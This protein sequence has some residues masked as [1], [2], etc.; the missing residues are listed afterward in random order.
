MV[1][2]RN[3]VALSINDST[4]QA[5]FFLQERYLELSNYRSE[6]VFPSTV[7]IMRERTAVCDS[8]SL[9]HFPQ[10]TIQH[11]YRLLGKRSSDPEV[12]E[13]RQR[14]PIPI[15]A[16]AEGEVVFE[17]NEEEW[18]PRDVVKRIARY[19]IDECQ[20]RMK[21][22]VEQC[23]LSV[24]DHLT[25]EEQDRVKRIV[26]SCGVEVL[27]V[28]KE[29]L[30]IGRY[31]TS[32]HCYSEDS[33]RWEN[34]SLLIF[35]LTH[36]DLTVTVLNMVDGTP[37]IA[38]EVYDPSLSG[39]VLIDI[40]L[41]YMEKVVLLRYQ[42]ELCNG[43]EGSSTWLSDYARLSVQ[44]E[45]NLT[46]LSQVDELLFDLPPTCS[47]MVR[48]KQKDSEGTLSL[49]RG[50]ILMIVQFF[51]ERCLEK[52]RVALQRLG[53]H[54]SDV[55][56]VVPVG[57]FSQMLFVKNALV[58]LFGED[59]VV[60]CFVSSSCLVKGLCEYGQRDCSVCGQT[61]QQQSLIHISETT[62]RTTIK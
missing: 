5:G 4:C 54:T 49:M 48:R 14:N 15:H 24:P 47:R 44:I 26:E 21:S 37:S 40:V 53:I 3:L 7:T 6:Y 51:V 22:P 30:C 59:S 62:R 57:P 52:V 46:L 29:S 9:K 18:S 38:C 16:N 31:L 35:S 60:R 32:E 61:R 28:I 39:R 11:A 33:V 41:H 20:K 36:S 2:D 8:H 1:L 45:E 23:V 50:E 25:Q 43:M 58:R 13:E 55:F 10:Y 42:C 27:Q 34:D 12:E 17:L 19:L 56:R